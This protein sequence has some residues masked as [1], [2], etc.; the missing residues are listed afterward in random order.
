MDRSVVIPTFAGF[1]LN[2]L[3]AYMKY[4]WYSVER[5]QVHEFLNMMNDKIHMLNFKYHTE[6][7]LEIL[8]ELGFNVC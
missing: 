6:T 7:V 5:F 4:F 2:H 8:V 3:S 1:D